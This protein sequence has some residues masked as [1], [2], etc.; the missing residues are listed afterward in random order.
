MG[1]WADGSDWSSGFTFKPDGMKEFFNM[2]KY[3]RKDPIYSEPEVFLFVVGTE[4][5]G[6][7]DHHLLGTEAEYLGKYHTKHTGL[8]LF[9]SSWGDPFVSKGEYSL[10]GELYRVPGNVLRGLDKKYS[11]HTRSKFNILVEDGCEEAWLYHIE[12]PVIV[13]FDTDPDRIGEGIRVVN[14]TRLEFLV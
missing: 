11:Q 9:K 3:D 6:Y 4:K 14:E 2:V 8:K 7:K 10:I 12:S 1:M 13:S 5:K